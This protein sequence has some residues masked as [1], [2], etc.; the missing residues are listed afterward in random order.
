MKLKIKEAVNSC[1]SGATQPSSIGSHKRDA[2]DM[3]PKNVRRRPRPKDSEVD[4]DEGLEKTH[5]IVAGLSSEGQKR[6]WIDHESD[7]NYARCPKC[8]SCWNWELINNCNMDYCPNCG[9]HNGEIVEVTMEGYDNPFTNAKQKKAFDDACDC[10]HNGYGKMYWKKNYRNGLDVSQI[11]DIWNRAY[12]YMNESVKRLNHKIRMET[13]DS[14]YI[15]NLKPN[16]ID[17]VYSIAY[18][19]DFP[20]TAKLVS[21]SPMSRM[22]NIVNRDRDTYGPVL[23]RKAYEDVE[24]VIT[25]DI[26]GRAGSP[27]YKATEVYSDEAQARKVFDKIK[28]ELYYID[29]TN[30]L[31]PIEKFF[32]FIICGS[33]IGLTEV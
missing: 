30:D 4:L 8:R 32:D 5:E 11:D 26:K 15:D 19:R 13:L 23:H 20:I 25:F 17:E 22:K 9:N 29:R 14:R 18:G 3:L 7:K 1:S 16:V 27:S 6:G 21:Q 24:Y 12:K 10:I 31:L 28:D 2:I 33:S